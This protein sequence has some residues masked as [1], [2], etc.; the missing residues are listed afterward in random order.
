MKKIGFVGAY[1]KID[2]IV[3][4][5]KIL[6]LCGKKVIVVDST[7]LQ[8]ARYIIPTM[9]PTA[10]YITDYEDIDFAIGYN[11][12]EQIKQY[13]HV[14]GD[15]PYDIM[16]IDIDNPYNIEGFG[17]NTANKNYFVTG[18]DQ[19]SIKRGMQIM[20]LVENTV[21]LSTIIFSQQMTGEEKK[22]IEY[23][24]LG[25]KI[26]WDDNEI[27]FPTENGDATYIAENQKSARISFRKLSSEYK[28]ALLALA[29]SLADDINEKQIKKAIKTL[30]E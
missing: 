19:F 22:Y 30:G 4:V 2:M 23:L 15:L 14:E 9:A 11:N 5:A 20:S 13:L 29:N 18:L 8:K 10:S 25:Y 21:N 17:L 26:V 12:I 1:D 6:T 24:S 3:N 7:I 27:Y 16:L 28:Y